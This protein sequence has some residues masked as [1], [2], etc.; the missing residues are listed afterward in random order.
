VRSQYQPETEILYNPDQWVL[1]NN[2]QQDH[3]EHLIRLWTAPNQ[4]L[5]WIW[6]SMSPASLQ[7]QTGIGAISRLH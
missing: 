3:R 6:N 1:I 5:I 4:Q 7:K 2:Y